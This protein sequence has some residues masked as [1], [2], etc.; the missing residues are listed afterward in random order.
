MKPVFYILQ[1][2]KKKKASEV[3]I[4]TATI[5]ALWTEELTDTAALGELTDDDVP[6]QRL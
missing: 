3:N 6:P 4:S 1:F 5:E 2:N